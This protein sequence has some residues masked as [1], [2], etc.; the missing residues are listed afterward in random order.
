MEI[1][2]KKIDIYLSSLQ[3]FNY[4]FIKYI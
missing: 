1:F 3:V 4:G 2:E